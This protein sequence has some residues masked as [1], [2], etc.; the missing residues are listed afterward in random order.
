M[1]LRKTSK[2]TWA[3][4]CKQLTA[5]DSATLL[6][7]LKDLY[8]ISSVNRDFLHARVFAGTGSTASF[9]EY[10]K[11]VVNPFYPPRG[12][13]NLKLGEARK[14]IRE[15]RK[16]TGDI[17]G[18][19]E[20]LLTFCETGAAFTNEFGDINER[21]YDSLDCGLGDLCELIKKQGRGAWEKVRD[22]LD[23]LAM[24]ADGIGWGYGDNTYGFVAELRKEFEP[25]NED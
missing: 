18:T 10:H 21:F 25:T 20:L 12:E 16:A 23:K 2:P 22:R 3:A 4:T 1:S 8:D 19:I 13:G 6:A 17:S 24:D 9:A 7:L 15:Y 11:R 5:C 14:A